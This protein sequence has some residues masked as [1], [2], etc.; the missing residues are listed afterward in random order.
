VNSEE[1]QIVQKKYNELVKLLD[2]YQAEVFG[3]W[4]SNIVDE[5]ESNLHKPLLCRDE[6]GLLKV[7]CDPKVVALLREVKY[8][9]A[10]TVQVP[11]KAMDV[12]SK[13]DELQDHIS[14]L[15]FIVTQYNNIHTTMIPVESPLIENRVKQ[16]DQQF[17]TA[18]IAII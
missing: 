8:F 14:N 1:A 18:S 12:Y 2:D 6:K 3:Y 17:E 9:N 16:I 11:Q 7:N 5:S 13:Q 15:D 4:S 10:L